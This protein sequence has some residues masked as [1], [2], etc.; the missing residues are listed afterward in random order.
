[1]FTKSIGRLAANANRRRTERDVRVHPDAGRV[2]SPS[3][4]RAQAR[5]ARTVL[6]QIQHQAAVAAP[7]GRWTVATD[8]G[9]LEG[10]ADLYTVRHTGTGQELRF[11][12]DREGA[13]AK[14][15]ALNRAA[16]PRA[17]CAGTIEQV[18]ADREWLLGQADSLAASRAEKEHERAR[19]HAECRDMW[20][21][22]QEMRRRAEDCRYLLGHMRYSA[23]AGPA[24]EPESAEPEP[25]PASPILH[26]ASDW[27]LPVCGESDDAHGEL[28]VTSE[29]DQV[30]CTQCAARLAAADAARTVPADAPAA[31]GGHHMPP[32]ERDEPDPAVLL[33]FAVML[34]VGDGDEPAAVVARFATRAE[35]DSYTAEPGD[36]LAGVRGHLYV[37]GPA[38][39]AA[40]PE[41]RTS[42]AHTGCP[43]TS[44]VTPGHSFW[45]SDH[46]GDILGNDEPDLP[47]ALASGPAAVPQL[48]RERDTETVRLPWGAPVLLDDT[49]TG[50]EGLEGRR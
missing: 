46:V 9:H 13:R 41:A 5:G 40:P 32:G 38:E 30:T 37:V 45:C 27:L 50:L 33:P 31:S 4:H 42:C 7:E 11:G 20:D 28:R 15:E 14:A 47:E 12:T 18:L 34:P 25:E 22:E 17:Y 1:M 8:H 29:R 23:A 16:E 21:A 43:R 36:A 2:P 48:R 19:I 49:L 10:R 6:P 39:A 3:T 35:A 44:F 24:E 26:A